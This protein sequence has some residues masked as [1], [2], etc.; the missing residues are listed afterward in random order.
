MEVVSCFTVL[1]ELQHSLNFLPARTEDQ[2][3][4]LQT[5]R[6]SRCSSKTG[7]RSLKVRWRWSC[8]ISEM[9]YELLCIYSM[10]FKLIFFPNHI[11]SAKIKTLI[12]ASFN[13]MITQDWW[14]SPLSPEV[15][16]HHMAY[17]AQIWSFSKGTSNPRWG[18]APCHRFSTLVHMYGLF[19]MFW[20]KKVVWVTKDALATFNMWI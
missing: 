12:L 16:L 17:Q 15:E 5:K 2:C 20:T 6:N 3:Y 14:W 1:Q 7:I 4:G 9:I 13:F 10:L 8:T 18:P 11:K 19:Q